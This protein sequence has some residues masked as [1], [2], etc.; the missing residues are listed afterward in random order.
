MKIGKRADFLIDLVNF[1]IW[2]SM[3]PKKNHDFWWLFPQIVKIHDLFMTIQI[4]E[5]D[6]GLFRFIHDCGHPGL[7]WQ[8]TPAEIT[9][10][11]DRMKRHLQLHFNWDYL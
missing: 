3:L 8:A 10:T 11:S 9:A 4:S 5:L 6:S 1:V 2:T 7:S